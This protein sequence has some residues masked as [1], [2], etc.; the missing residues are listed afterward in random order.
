V[1]LLLELRNIQ[2][3]PGLISSELTDP[4]RKAGGG[5]EGFTTTKPKPEPASSKEAS[6]SPSA[7]IAAGGVA[8]PERKILSG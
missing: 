4:A 1:A 3:G 7:P 5:T 8:T 6:S 2:A